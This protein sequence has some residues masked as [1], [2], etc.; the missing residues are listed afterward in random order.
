MFPSAEQIAPLAAITGTL[1]DVSITQN[2]ATPM[3]AT[4]TRAQR[5]VV[6]QS[7]PN[8]TAVMRVGA[9]DVDATHGVVI[10]VGGCAFVE[11][12][13]AAKIYVFSAGAG[14]VACGMVL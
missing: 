7:S 12:Y 5:G 4:A 11:V 9:A 14:Q 2:V 1:A 10:P 13:D 6:V 3:S 8:N